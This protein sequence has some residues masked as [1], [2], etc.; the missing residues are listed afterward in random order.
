M[1]RRISD[2][3]RDHHKLTGGSHPASVCRCPERGLHS[4][5]L[6]NDSNYQARV[7]CPQTHLGSIAPN[8]LG[9]PSVGCQ[10]PTADFNP[11]SVENSGDAGEAPTRLTKPAIGKLLFHLQRGVLSIW[12]PSKPS[13]SPGVLPAG[14]VPVNAMRQLK[15]PLEAEQLEPCHWCVF[16]KQN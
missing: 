6:S 5:F 4:S 2:P 16:K 12:G 11:E 7:P 1:A 13:P 3:G 9:P 14:H 15:V 8:S 10:V